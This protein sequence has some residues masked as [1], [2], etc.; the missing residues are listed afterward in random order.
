MK[1]DLSGRC[2]QLAAGSRDAEK[3]NHPNKMDISR[4]NSRTHHA[5]GRGIHTCVG[6][7]LARREISICIEHMINKFESIELADSNKEHAYNPNVMLRGLK[8]LDIETKVKN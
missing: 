6:N 4:Q 8:V 3:F 5:F 1:H 7:M 2:L